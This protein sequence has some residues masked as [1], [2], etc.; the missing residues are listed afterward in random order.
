MSLKTK[1]VKKHPYLTKDKRRRGEEVIIAGTGIKVI[2]VAIRYEIMCMA[3]EDIMI[4]YPHLTLPQ[5]HD[6]LSYYYEHKS[7]LD[8]KWKQALK[9]IEKLKDSH[10][11]PLEEKVGRIKNI[12]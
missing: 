4:A 12:Y 3:P 9:K 5:I 8:H 2:D 1:E 10:I 11:S 7:E 6:A